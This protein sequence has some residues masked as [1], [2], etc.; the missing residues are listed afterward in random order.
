VT[1]HEATGMRVM[2][3]TDDSASARKAEEWVTRLRYGIPPIVDVVC[4][5]GRGLTRLG[6]GMQSYRAPVRLA[7]EGLRQSELYAAERIANEVG[8]RLQGAGLTVHT[9]ARQGDCCEELLAMVG[10]DRPDLVVVGPRGRSGLAAAILGS[11]THGLIANAES[12][13][14]VARPPLTTEGRLPEHVLLVADGTA[15]APAAVDWLDR[16]GW[17]SGGRVTVLGLLGDRAGLEY[18]EPALID[19]V[20]RLVRSD[21]TETLEQLAQ[22]FARGDI[23]L[24]FALRGGHPLQASL[25]VAAEFGVDLV[26]VARPL[27]H[28]GRDRIAEKIAR[29]AAV[30]VLLVPQP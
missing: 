19:E 29:H 7:V 13:V 3:A 20:T 8:E 26:A 24:D 21:A 5:A 11:V 18:E 27:R 17:L 15:S 9:W 2:L 1:T 23:A 30:S 16:A 25:D 10:V 28:Q 14:L 22:P 12:P 4:V 6:W